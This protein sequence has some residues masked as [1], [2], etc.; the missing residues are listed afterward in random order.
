MLT[1]IFNLEFL[2]GLS[3]SLVIGLS[4]VSIIFA[5][6]F[7]LPSTVWFIFLVFQVSLWSSSWLCFAL[8]VAAS[9]LLFIPFVRSRI[10]SSLVLRLLNKW[11]VVPKIS[12][13]ER[14]A[15]EAG[16]TWIEKEFFSSKPSIKKILNQKPAVLT[17]EEQAFLDGPTQELC[18]KIDDWKIWKSRDIEE[19]TLQFIKEKKFLGMIIP[20]A[21]GGLEFSAAAHSAVIQKI[22][23]RSVVVGI[24]VMVPNS[25]GPAELLIHYGTQKQK[26]YYL[27]RLAI[28][29]EIPCFGLTEPGAGSDA[30]SITS[31]GVLFKEDGVIKIRLNWNKRW[32]TLASI[33]TVIGL[34]FRLKDPEALLGGKKDLGI[35][36][37]LIP[38]KTEGVVLGRRHDPMSIAFYNCPT[39][40]KDVVVEAE[41]SIIGG[42]KEA[43]QGWKMLMKCLSVG[44]GISLVATSTGGIKLVTKT[45]SNHALIRRQFGMPIGNFEGVE[46]VLAEMSGICYKAEAVR[47]YT[48][49]ALNQEIS[50]PVVTAMAKY[51]TTE[52]C[53]TGCNKAMDILAGS[54]ISMGPKNQVAMSYIAS[55]IGITVEGANILTRTLIIFGQGVFRAHPYA[56]LEMQALAEGDVKKF[57]KAFFSHLGHIFTNICRT[58]LFSISRGY[59]YQKNSVPGLKRYVQKFMWATSVFSLMSDMAMAL[60]GGSLKRKEKMTGRF[61][62][63]LYNLYTISAIF[64]KYSHS[65]YQTEEELSVVKNSLNQV[66]YDIQ[67]A[68]DGIFVNFKVP[69]VSWFFTHFIQYWSS[70]NIIGVPSSDALSHKAAKVLL[71]DSDFRDS[72]FEGIFLSKN[73]DDDF[74]KQ[75]QAFKITHESKSLEKKFKAL[76]K[77]NAIPK[78]KIDLRLK[79]ALEKNLLTQKEYDFLLKAH[80]M[81]WDC[82]QVNDFS[83]EEFRQA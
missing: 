36:C 49:S 21:Q 32:I 14:E 57:D 64:H 42:L 79:Q 75:T 82:I 70:F 58:F 73:S 50:P 51:S 24:T 44:R 59:I 27:P 39:Q 35:T 7:S 80:Q 72:L 13:T 23:S 2:F 16:Q 68:F 83:E 25:L 34:A 78:G 11:K 29:K 45:S 3:S 10:I 43:G 6:Y 12:S 47:A 54:G 22:S 46:E 62:D 41:T 55:P 20:K 9:I 33:S 1:Q 67:K 66:F 48:L 53:R 5:A 4:L 37:A 76:C 74:F 40:G 28:G 81:R 63:V 69:F 61:A 8:G 52:W 30:S 15:L 56:L 18:E 19:E 65:A 71:R 77:K 26:D 38:S 60:M 31:E 17:Q